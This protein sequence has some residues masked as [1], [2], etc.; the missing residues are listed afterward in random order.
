MI[1]KGD[2]LAD[3]IKRAGGF[4]NDAYLYGAVFTRESVR[5]MQEKRLK[6]MIYKLK[7]KIAIL[8]ASAK[9]A[10]ENSLDAKNLMDAIDA[11][12]IQA[13]KLKPIGRIALNL[14][15]NL[16]KFEKSSYNIVLENNDKL[17]IP[18][19]KDSVIVMGEVLTPTAFV[20]TN[21][22]AVKYIKQAGGQTSLADDIFFVVHANGF[23]EK[24]DFGAIF[25]DD[26]D[27]KAGDAITVPIQIKTSTWYG[28]T[29]DITS[30]LYQ[31]AIT[32]ASLKTV[33]AF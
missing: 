9:G 23:T 28:I 6:Q 20:Y 25:D 21:D 30:I 11:V 2:K 3:I 17:Y 14:D 18:S 7:K 13:Q 16:T 29:K 19:K 32:A 1:E 26:V 31:L 24:G 15:K 10:G 27:V 4:T 33:G 8:S 22:S 12:A 5:K